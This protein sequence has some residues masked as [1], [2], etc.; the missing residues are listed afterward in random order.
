MLRAAALTL[1]GVLLGLAAA[2]GAVAAEPNE[3]K[4]KTEDLSA[5]NNAVAEPN[6]AGLVR[7]LSRDHVNL[8]K[9]RGDKITDVV[10]DAQALEVSADKE[11]GIVFVQVKPR[12]LASHPGQAVTSAFFNTETENHAVR[13]VAADV[14]SQSI[15]L[16]ADEKSLAKGAATSMQRLQEAFSTPLAP[17]QAEDY[18]AQLKEVIKSAAAG[19]GYEAQQPAVGLAFSQEQSALLP[20]ELAETARASMNG[21]AVRQSRVWVSTEF[22]CE[23]LHF[24]NMNIRKTAI[25]LGEIAQTLEGVLAIGAQALEFEPGTSGV[26]YVIR[27]RAEMQ[28]RLAAGVSAAS[29]SAKDAAAVVFAADSLGAADGVQ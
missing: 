20:V 25:D 6:A 7:P 1:F 8:V 14:P 24:T 16:H 18:I 28:K 5:A 13:F 2:F 15:E 9:V 21:F 27:A 3:G 29:L 23:E 22:V 10:F 26:V 17:L 11:R 4:S 19:K 12:W